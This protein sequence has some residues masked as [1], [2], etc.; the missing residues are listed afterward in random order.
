MKKKVLFL[1]SRQAIK[2][3]LPAVS[4]STSAGQGLDWVQQMITACAGQCFYDYINIVSN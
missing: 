3:S 1:I 2:K 4:S